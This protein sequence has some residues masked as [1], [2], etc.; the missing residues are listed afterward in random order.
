MRKLRLP[1]S[2]VRDLAVEILGLPALNG[3]RWDT[4]SP[5]VIEKIMRII[6]SA[7][8]DPDPFSSEKTTMNRAMMDR[9]GFFEDVVANAED[10]LFTA[11]KLAIAGNAID[12]MVPNS[13]TDL[14]ASIMAKRQAPLAR[15]AF[16]RFEQ[17]LASSASLVVLGDN[18]GE[19]VLDRLFIETIRRR[20]SLDV[21]FVVR[22]IPTLNDA[23]PA[24][25][26]AVG[27]D[28]AARVVGN[29]IDGPLPGTIPRRCTAEVQ[30]LMDHA[31]LIIA[32]G[33]GNFDC[34]SEPNP[35]RHKTIFMLLSKCYPVNRYFKT[36]H[37]HPILSSASAK[38]TES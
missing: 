13:I 10:P 18:A 9:Y 29:G 25:A 38:T 30:G 12:F 8:G 17:K 33:G 20:Y 37:F 28:K 7:V 11:A 14:K 24:E 2:A 5:E 36:F 16:Q 4:T 26:A 3:R 1:E 34:L 27:M 21:V 35:Y 22:S 19:I 15:G 31:D 6:A 23:T 32:K